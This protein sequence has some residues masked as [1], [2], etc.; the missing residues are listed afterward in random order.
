ML[1]HL[2]IRNYT[3]VEALDLELGPGMTVITGETGAGKSIMLDA[4][5]LCLGDRADPRAVRAGCD[6]AE[7]N[8]S[9]DIAGNS[10]ALA[11]L[12]DNELATEGECVI[13]RSVT[14]EGRSRAWINGSVATLQALA[15]LGELLIDIHSQHAHQS[16]LRRPVQRDLVD[17]YG[18][19]TDLARRVEQFADDWQ[20]GDS[21]LA[22]LLAAREAQAARAQLLR[23]QLEELDALALTSAE[24][25][26]LGDEQ[27]LL[28]NAEQILRDTAAAREL[29]ESHEDGVRQARQLLAGNRHL[30]SGAR[31]IVELLDSAAIALSEA[32]TELARFHDGVELNPE[33]LIEVEQRLSTVH[34]IA[35]KHRVLPEQLPELHAQLREEL[36]SL[37]SSDARAVTLGSEL[38]RI[39]G[40]W[41]DAA[42]ALGK[43]R[44][45]AGKRLASAVGEQLDALAMGHS[46]FRVCLTPRETDTPHP[47]GSEDIELRIATQPGSEPQP[48]GRIAS[49][50]ELSRIALAIQVATARTATVPAMVFDE[51]D[52]GVGGA[53]AEIVGRLLRQLSERTQI[54]CVTHLPQVAA[55]GQQHLR[56]VKAV[57]SK[58][59][60]TRLETLSEQEKVEEIARMLGGIT[61][62][63]QTRAHAREMLGL[64]GAA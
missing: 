43:A 25:E 32:Q 40:A 63:E 14:S 13:R 53:V 27:T 60:R 2:Q 54:L 49:G 61:V 58:S 26:A 41:R 18:G 11:W 1:S 47:G 38:A 21:E 39:H 19:H 12:A 17:A 3:V 42:G 33:R 55:Q 31:E 45:Q 15:E 37:S 8:A 7:V 50:G 62:T 35:R 10:A 34:S 57:D 24:L 48:L 59:V 20:R 29:C 9:F 64:A 5:G 44:T 56:V 4:L 22:A 46:R 52:S 28:A 6:R 23:Y 16:L 30:G 51:V 36:D